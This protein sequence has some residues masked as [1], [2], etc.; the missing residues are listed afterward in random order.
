MTSESTTWT[1]SETCWI[2]NHPQNT[3]EWEAVGFGRITAYWFSACTGKSRFNT[4]DQA[5]DKALG[6]ALPCEENERMKRGNTLEPH[7]VQWFGKWA[8][9]KC[10]IVGRAVPI[11]DKDIGGSADA[12]V[13]EDE[14]LEVKVSDD[15]YPPLLK[16]IQDYSLGIAAPGFRHIYDDHYRQM[17]GTMA[18]YGRKAANYL[19]YGAI[20]TRF[21]HQ[22]VPFD[23]SFWTVQLYAPVKL[24]VAE[25]KRRAVELE[26][27]LSRR[28]DP[29]DS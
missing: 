4:K 26:I 17:Q 1:K 10:T 24:A 21:F 23:E 11:W 27:D 18:V 22:K 28:I 5:I 29:P 2:S 7:L 25:M 6:I 20:S 8:N 3:P 15:V 12:L 16:Y 14:I 13:G 9:V 19:N